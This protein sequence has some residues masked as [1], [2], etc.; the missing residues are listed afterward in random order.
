MLAI[1]S[2]GITDVGKKRKNNEDALFFDDDLRLYIVADGMG[3]HLA[4]EVASELVVETIRDYLI[5]FKAGRDAEELEDTDEN[6]SIEANRLLS[7][8]KL[9][10]QGVYQVARNNESYHGMG[11]T[12]SAVYFSDDTIVAANVGDSPVYLVR[13]GNIELLSVIH[14]VLAEQ[15]AK[16]PDAAKMLGPE[17][18]HMLTRAVGIEE[19]VSADICEIPYV[20][21]DVITISSDGLSDKVTSDEILNVVKSETPE[22]ACRALVDLAN[23]RGGDDNI[24]VI[25]LKVKTDRRDKNGILGLISNVFYSMKKK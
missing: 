12:V 19:T 22:I 8:I 16:N 1:E 4:G 9:A 14:N 18:K 7:G 21:S 10:N 17:Y 13:K 2:A 5:R 11:S 23:M 24:S 3:G 6:L 15:T 25:I 20:D